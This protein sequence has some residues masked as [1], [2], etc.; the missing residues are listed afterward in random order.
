MTKFFSRGAPKIVIVGD[1]F[2]NLALR[3]SLIVKEVGQCNS[4]KSRL[5]STQCLPLFL[6]VT[7]SFFLLAF[8]D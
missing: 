1:I 8:W 2:D 3:I 5:L 4:R 6:L 7:L